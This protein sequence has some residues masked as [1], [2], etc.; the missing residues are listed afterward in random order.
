MG[1]TP[2]SGPDGLDTAGFS[3]G[4]PPY[5]HGFSPIIPRETPLEGLGQVCGAPEIG[6]G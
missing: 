2:L 5:T 4:F 6:L 1:K 3:L